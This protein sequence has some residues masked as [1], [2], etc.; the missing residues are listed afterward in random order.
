MILGEKQ[1]ITW[2]KPHPY[3]QPTSVVHRLGSNSSEV[4][5]SA[6]K[7]TDFVKKFS[8]EKFLLFINFLLYRPQQRLPIASTHQVTPTR[9]VTA[10]LF[11]SLQ[12]P[13][14]HCLLPSSSSPSWLAPALLQPVRRR[15]VQGSPCGPPSLWIAAHL[16][17]WPVFTP[18][19]PS[20][21][22]HLYQAFP[23]L[24]SLLQAGMPS[25]LLPTRPALA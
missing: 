21:Q 2:R 18:S 8:Q 19:S 1:C 22:Q 17:A 20:L 24:P 3:L 13:P 25:S 5:V 23:W 14:H 10:A 6:Q 16:V 12:L 15:V 11:P 4:P 7:I 9:P